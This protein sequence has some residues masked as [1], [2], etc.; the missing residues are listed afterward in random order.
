MNSN[1]LNVFVSIMAIVLLSS[2]SLY[3]SEM[4]QKI[5]AS[6]KQTYVFKTLLKDDNI[7]VTSS[8]GAVVLKGN[9]AEDT[10]KKLAKETVANLQGVKSVDNQLVVNEPAEESDAWISM[11]IKYSLL[12]NRYVSGLNTKVFVTDGIVTLKG[13][14]VNQGQKDLAEEYAKDVKGVKDVKNEMTISKMKSESNQTMGEKIDDASITAQVKVAFLFHHST[15]AFKTG[16]STK[17][18]IVTL[19]GMANSEAGKTMATKVANDVNGV[20]NVVNNMTV[21]DSLTKKVEPYKSHYLD[22]DMAELRVTVN[23][24]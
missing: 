10:H 21:K 12:Y 2:V 9:V 8:E 5:V 4:D 1:Y 20:V 6:V 3:A 17:E 18:G 14:V 23:A 24:V 22:N 7:N 15:S 11:Q 16:V 13:E 19:T